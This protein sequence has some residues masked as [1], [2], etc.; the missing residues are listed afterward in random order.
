MF[1]EV[2]ESKY[3]WVCSEIGGFAESESSMDL[4]RRSLQNDVAM[5]PRHSDDKV[6]T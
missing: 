1:C 3:A 2:A 6:G 5:F 4:P